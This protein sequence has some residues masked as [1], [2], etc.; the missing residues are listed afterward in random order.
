M[1]CTGRTSIWTTTEYELIDQST[2][3]TIT[4]EIWEGP[5]GEGSYGE[6]CEAK[7]YVDSPIPTAEGD[8]Y[9]AFIPEDKDDECDKVP[10]ATTKVRATN[11]SDIEMT[12]LEKTIGSVG[13]IEEFN[14]LM[15]NIRTT[16]YAVNVDCCDGE[17]PPNGGGNSRKMSVGPD[18]VGSVQWGHFDAQGEP[19]PDG[20]EAVLKSHLS[21]A[22]NP[23][24]TNGS[25]GYGDF[26]RVYDLGVGDFG[27]KPVENRDRSPVE[28]QAENYG[29]CPMIDLTGGEDGFVPSAVFTDM[30]NDGALTAGGDVAAGHWVKVMLKVTVVSGTANIRGYGC[31]CDCC[32]E[33]GES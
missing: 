8:A 24:I 33:G 15:A 12:A 16:I 10:P 20:F 17:E 29:E 32:E 30:K 3:W 6:E 26:D 18:P 31:H 11:A 19:V 22:M 28:Q 13:A 4:G 25:N 23:E 7:L 1:G 21:D 5:Q 9:D 14:S 27:L 2:S